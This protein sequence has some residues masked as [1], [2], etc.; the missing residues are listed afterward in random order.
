MNKIHYTPS[1]LRQLKKLEQSLQEEIFEK[2][3]IFQKNPK[4]TQLKTHKLKGRIQGSSSF[5]VNYQYRII[6]ETLDSNGFVLVAVGNHDVY[7]K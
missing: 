6:F 7:K 2:V 1:F 5:S 3:A 4:D